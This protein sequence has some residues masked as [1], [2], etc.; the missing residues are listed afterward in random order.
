MIWAHYYGRFGLGRVQGAAM[1][2]GITGAAV[3][4]LPL[5]LF[6]DLTGSYDVGVLVMA[7]LPL[8]SI[9]TVLLGRPERRIEA[10]IAATR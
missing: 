3:G 4:P 9:A 10:G 6:R 2:A 7:A 1:M 8:F 5:A